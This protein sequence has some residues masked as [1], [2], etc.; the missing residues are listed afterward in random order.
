VDNLIFNDYK[1]IC[2][3]DNCENKDIEITLSVLE[4]SQ[5]MCGPCMNF[6]TDIEKV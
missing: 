2:H 3:T 1:V 5:I 4:G 6:I